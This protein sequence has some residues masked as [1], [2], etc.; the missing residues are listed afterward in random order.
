MSEERRLAAMQRRVDRHTSWSR[1]ARQQARNMLYGDSA[2]RAAGKAWWHE[3][4]NQP[5]VVLSAPNHSGIG[6][7]EASP[8]LQTEGIGK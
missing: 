8:H 3:Q 2:A 1:E 4:L 7:G 5:E 6:R